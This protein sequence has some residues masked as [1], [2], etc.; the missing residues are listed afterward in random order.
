MLIEDGGRYFAAE[1][2]GNILELEPRRWR[3]PRREDLRMNEKRVQVF[4]EKFDKFDWT[5]M[6]GR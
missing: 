6:L 4:R 5:K 1:I 2:I 3:R